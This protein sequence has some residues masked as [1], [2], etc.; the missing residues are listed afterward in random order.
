VLGLAGP[1]C[2]GGKAIQAASGDGYDGAYLKE[3]A[4]S[5][6]CPVDQPGCCPQLRDRLVKARAEHQM[7]EVAVTLDALA[8]AC[9]SQRAEALAALDHRPPEPPTGGL[10]ALTYVLELG[11]EDRLY[12]LGAFLDGR[13]FPRHR[14]PPGPH[15]LQ[16]E[17]H[18]MTTGAAKRL[19][20]LRAQ[21]E[22]VL[23]PDGK[24]LVVIKR[25][26]ATDTANPFALLMPDAWKGLQAG[27]VIEGPAKRLLVETPRPRS[28]GEIRYPSEIRRP[29]T[30]AVTLV[31]VSEQGKVHAVQPLSNNHPRYQASLIDA[32]FHTEY[33]PHLVEG[34]A[35]PS[36][37]LLAAS[38]D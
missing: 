14:V 6:G 34:R 24:A 5:E 8:I 10:V 11:P 37:H 28:I 33:P 7:R 22:V 27:S 16:V 1:G 12:W 29:G 30:K 32:L 25:V 15:D 17:A 3:R 21:K 9:P 35:V 19:F 23:D 26:S 18:V 36:C 2:A 13:A 20:T 4:A 38:W 31:C